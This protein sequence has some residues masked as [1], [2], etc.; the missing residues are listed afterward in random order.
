MKISDDPLESFT[1]RSTNVWHFKVRNKQNKLQ[2]YGFLITKIYVKRPNFRGK[3]SRIF[4]PK[5]F[6]PKFIRPK[7]FAL[8]LPT[9]SNIKLS[10][11]Q[12]THF[13]GRKVVRKTNKI[14]SF[15][16]KNLLDRSF[17]IEKVIFYA[18]ISLAIME[19]WK[20]IELKTNDGHEASSLK[21]E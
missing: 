10:V 9:F 3:S 13:F 5:I 6:C 1:A 2:I 8:N 20:E 4:R 16:M 18:F 19:P 11:R 21:I 12:K 17:S 7:L 15:M 14:P